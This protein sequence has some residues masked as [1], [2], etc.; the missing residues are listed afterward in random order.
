MVTSVESTWTE[1]V[2]TFVI[3][4]M[5]GSMD[6]KITVEETKA[7]VIGNLPLAAM[8][9]QGKIKQQFEDDLS[10]LLRS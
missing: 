4:S 2:M 7:V 10:R 3:K 6:G 1:N 8:M 9:F 5:I